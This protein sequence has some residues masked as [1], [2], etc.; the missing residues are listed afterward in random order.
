MPVICSEIIELMEEIAPPQY[1]EDWDN[2]GLL[3]GDRRQAIHKIM[4]ALDVTPQVLDSAVEQGVQLIISH[5]PPL[6]K[7]IKQLRGDLPGTKTLCRLVKNDIAVYAAHTTLDAAPAGV[8]DVLAGKLG[9]EHC[10][11]LSNNKEILYK[12]AVCVPESHASQVWEAIAATG[13]GHI[14]NYSHCSF[15]I[16]GT[17][18]FKP[19]PGTHPFIGEPGKMESVAECRLE[20]VFPA[21]LRAKVL[22]TMLNAHP[23]EEV[24][25]D[26]YCLANEQAGG[27]G[28]IGT[29]AKPAPLSEFAAQVKQALAVAAVKVAGLSDK[30][31]HKVALCG[32]SGASLLTQAVQAGADVLVTGDVDYHDALTALEQGVAVIDAGHFGTEYPV[33]E[34]LTGRLRQLAHEKRWDVQI[35]PAVQAD[36]FTY[37]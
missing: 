4:V 16:H 30:A 32:G 25:Y 6:F 1:A 14:G 29:L 15:Q 36:V 37:L 22:K 35:V 3:V 2:A 9:L 17:G 12:L 28:R 8:N 26:L 18:T 27:L 34:A 24:A 21:R 20:T 33:V 23:Y 5:H 13:A 10:E 31:I 11:A 7:A 19:L